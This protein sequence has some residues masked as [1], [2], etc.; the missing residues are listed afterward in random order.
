V[1]P[2]AADL[3]PDGAT[4]APSEETFAATSPREIRP[5]SSS[6]PLNRNAAGSPLL[7][8][9]TLAE[10]LAAVNTLRDTHMMDKDSAH[11]DSFDME[12]APTSIRM[13]G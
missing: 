4:L 3:P 11:R 10:L 12:H 13:P 9:A 7:S 2:N 6:K 5:A 8:E 1:P